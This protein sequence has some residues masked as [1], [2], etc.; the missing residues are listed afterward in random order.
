VTVF[1]SPSVHCTEVNVCISCCK[2][3]NV[4]T[5]SAALLASASHNFTMIF[6]KQAFAG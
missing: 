1:R 2:Q 5:A 4:I 3:L 6:L